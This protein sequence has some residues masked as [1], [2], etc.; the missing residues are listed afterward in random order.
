MHATKARLAAQ[1]C[2]SSFLHSKT[3]D[4]TLLI[5][6]YWHSLVFFACNLA[7]RKKPG[8][9]ATSSDKSN[10]QTQVRF[11]P[12]FRPNTKMIQFRKGESV[13]MR[14]AGGNDVGIFIAG[15]QEGSAA[16]QEGLEEGDQLLKVTL[17]IL[18][19]DKCT[20]CYSQS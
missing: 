7:L 6:I 4:L 1:S 16:E 2:P 19:L 20:F 8:N 9:I 13:G 18:L 17:V 11:F 10:L 14:L 5:D 3:N 12:L 15:V